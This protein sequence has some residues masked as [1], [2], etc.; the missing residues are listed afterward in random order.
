MGGHE[1]Q[2]PEKAGPGAALSTGIEISPHRKFPMEIKMW[3]FNAFPF[4]GIATFLPAIALS[5]GL[6]L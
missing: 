1:R 2:S 5:H 4:N 3:E 6:K